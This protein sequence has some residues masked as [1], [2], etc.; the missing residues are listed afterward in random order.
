MKVR[1][2]LFMSHPVGS[3]TGFLQRLD[4]SILVAEHHVYNLFICY[5]Q[6]LYVIGTVQEMYSALDCLCVIVNNFLLLLSLTGSSWLLLFVAW[7]CRC[8]TTGA[9]SA[10]DCISC[11]VVELYINKLYCHSAY[12]AN[13]LYIVCFC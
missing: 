4:I 11:S 13:G 5:C 1:G 7:Q 12:A 2:L 8:L 10:E 3:A 9:I 6:L